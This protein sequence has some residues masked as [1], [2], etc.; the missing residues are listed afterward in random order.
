MSGQG[1]REAMSLSSRW[2]ALNC[3]RA[4]SAPASV[5]SE[6]R[7]ASVAARAIGSSIR[8]TQTESDNTGTRDAW[9][10][11]AELRYQAGERIWLSASLGPEFSSDSESDDNDVGVRADIEARYI[12]NERWSWVNSLG[13]GTVASPSDTGYL[14]NNYNFSTEL[15]HQLI[16]GRISGGLSFDYSAYQSVA[17]VLIERENEENMSLFLSYSR[18][19]WSERVMFDSSVRYRVNSGDRDWSQWLVSTGLNIQF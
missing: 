8:Y 5:A 17:D 9:A 18:A 1:D 19:L 3:S 6:R 12:I 2:Q 13:T 15:E 11:L 4:S 16:R 14:V 7:P 10:L